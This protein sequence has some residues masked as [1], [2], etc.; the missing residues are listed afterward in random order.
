MM[1][2]VKCWPMFF[3]PIAMGV[4]TFEIRIADRPYRLFDTLRLNEWTDD[5][6][7]TGRSLDR[8]I[9]YIMTGGGCPG[10]DMSYVVLG[11]APL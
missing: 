9:I 10:L 4:K 5:D 2:E 11:L 1:H 6:G 7:F 3:A 8:R